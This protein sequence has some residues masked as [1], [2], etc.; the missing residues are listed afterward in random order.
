MSDRTRRKRGSERSHGMS[1]AKARD[2]IR[3][4]KLY[5]FW[6]LF[7][8]YIGS[9]L[10]ASILSLF[11]TISGTGVVLV[12]SSSVFPVGLILYIIN[13]QILIALFWTLIVHSLLFFIYIFVLIFVFLPK[14]ESAWALFIL[15]I[16]MVAILLVDIVLMVLLRAGR[17]SFIN[18]YRFLD[19]MRKKERSSMFSPEYEQARR[20]THV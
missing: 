2:S 20:D 17:W 4:Y 7:L 13:Y 9:I 12:M 6:P 14:S 5:F 16:I 18:L 8:G 1:K 15:I 11:P 19:R 10:I 3:H